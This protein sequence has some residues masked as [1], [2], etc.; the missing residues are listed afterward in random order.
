MILI[1]ITIWYEVKQ[2]EFLNNLSDIPLEKSIKD[3]IVPL[4]I[5]QC[6]L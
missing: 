5:Q 3:D 2:I 6:T 4:N 1:I